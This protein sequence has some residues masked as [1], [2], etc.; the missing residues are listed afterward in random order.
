[1]KSGAEKGRL[2]CS[3]RSQ[4]PGWREEGKN[5]IRGGAAAPGEGEESVQFF[6]RVFFFFFV[7]SHLIAKF[8]LHICIFTGKMFFELQNSSINFFYIKF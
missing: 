1:V 3:E 8:P 4:A 7:A 2:V 6:F 5:L